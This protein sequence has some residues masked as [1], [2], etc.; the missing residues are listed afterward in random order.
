MKHATHCKFCKI[1]ITVE[2]D[3]GYEKHGDPYKLLPMACCNECADVRVLRRSITR[4][5]QF[6][7]RILQMAGTNATDEMI[8]KSRKALTSLT[9]AYAKMIS[10]W[11]KTEGMAWDEEIV[12]QLIEQP[13]QWGVIITQMWKMYKDSV[14]QKEQH[15]CVV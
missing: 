15:E 3:D 6:T 11:N 7:C 4:K 8:S 2:I 14:A 5:I 12:N 9:Q 10:R 13:D 1:P